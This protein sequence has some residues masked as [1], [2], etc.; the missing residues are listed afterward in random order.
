MYVLLLSHNN[1]EC[2]S[3][4]YSILI[5]TIIKPGPYWVVPVLLFIADSAT[6][7]EL[8]KK[9]QIS[10]T[11]TCADE[12]AIEYTALPNHELA[13][14]LTNLKY[15]RMVIK[16]KNMGGGASEAKC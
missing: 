12:S 8:Y 15:H 7:L 11:F 13:E 5:G 3:F 4:T 9:A 6:N 2:N 1:D 10:E 16:H 14:L